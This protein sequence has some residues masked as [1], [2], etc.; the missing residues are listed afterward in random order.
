MIYQ[1]MTAKL[2]AEGNYPFFPIIEGPAGRNVKVRGIGDTIMLASCDYLGLSN[3]ERIKAAAIEGIK[4]FGTNICGSLAFSGRTTIHEQLEDSIKTYM[5]TESSIIFPTSYLANLG[6]LSTVATH[7]DVLLFDNQNHVSLFGGARMSEAT[8]RTYKHNDMDM[9]ESLLKW[10]H[11]F[12]KRFIVTDGIFSAIGDYAK[13]DTIVQLAKKYDAAIILD[14]A[15]DLGVLGENGRGL[16]EHFNVLDDIDLIV[17]TMSKAMGSTG[18]FV[19]G[20]EKYIGKMHYASGPYHSSRAVS[21]GVAA[22]SV[23]AFE[24]AK[25]EGAQRRHQL[26]KNTL[27]INKGLM[28]LGFDTMGTSTPVVPVLIKD[29]ERTIAVTMWLQKHSILVCGMVPPSTPTNSAR[30]RL[31]VTSM[32]NEQDIDTVLNVFDELSASSLWL[33]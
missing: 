20:K 32:L 27:A 1:Q 7:D 15:H 17:G 30:L 23:K 3:D 33:A 6:C 29:T 14:S 4:Q 16:A 26:S 18:G 25:T 22:A 8:L 2:K 10:S 13:L 5:G 11:G 9:L 12:K 21:P 19:V 24:I 28:S 31:N